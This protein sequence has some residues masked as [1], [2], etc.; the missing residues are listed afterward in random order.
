MKDSV[1]LRKPENIVKFSKEIGFVE[2]VK[3]SGNGLWKGITK[4]DLLRF[5]AKSYNLKP[6]ELGKTKSDI[7]SNL[8]NLIL[9][10]GYQM[11]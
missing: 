10:S 3:I 1:L 11:I 4:A 7:H 5:A 6:K 2:D 9:R 8:V